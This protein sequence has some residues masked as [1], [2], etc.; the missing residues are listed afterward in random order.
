MNGSSI[1]QSGAKANAKPAE[2]NIKA[3]KSAESDNANTHLSAESA[4]TGGSSDS[5]VS[6]LIRQAKFWHDKMQ[7]AKAMQSLNRVLLSDPHNEEALYLMSLWSYQIND[8]EAAASYREKLSKIAPNS[9]Y[10]QMLDNQRGISDLSSD[11][12]KHA[13]VLASS[14]NINAALIEYQKLFSGATPPKPL[15]AEYYLTMAGDPNYYD[16][17][18]NGVINYIRQNPKD[19]NAQITYGKILSYRKSTIR[20]GIEL[21]DYLAPHTDDA[22]KA[23]RDALIWLSPTNEDEKYYSSYLSRHAND[24]EVRRHFDDTIIGNLSE[25]AYSDA[26]SDKEDAIA[27]FEQIL[28]KNPNNQDALEAV[29]YLQMELKNFVKAQEY[30]NKAASLGGKKE[31]KLRHDAAMAAANLAVQTGDLSL[32]SSTL[33]S[34]L[35]EAPYDVGALMLKADICKK[36]KKFD[37]AERALRTALSAD[38]SN[39]GANEM[40]FY[41]YREQGKKESAD[42]LLSSMPDHVRQKIKQAIAGKGYTDPV[43][44]IRSR[45]ESLAANGQIPAAIETLQEAI[46]KYPNSPWL[47]YDLAKLLGDNGFTAGAQS[48]LGYLTR[49]NA[50]NED[51]FAA[52]SLLNQMG[53][54]NQA[55][56]AVK[57]ISS[58]TAKVSELKRQITISQ[59]FGTVEEYL[60]AGNRQA[61]CNSLQMM[62]ISPSALS[63][64]QLGHMAYLYLQCG[65]KQRALELADLALTRAVDPNA[66]IGDYADLVTVYNQTGYYDK[67]RTL[68]A[69]QSI[70]ANSKQADI[71]RMNIGD[72]IRK[73]D[74]LRDMQHYA[75]AYDILY[76]LIEQNPDDVN[77]NMA[78]ARLYQD[79]GKYVTAGQIYHR[80]LKND[81][82]NQSALEGAINACLADEDFDEAAYLADRLTTSNDP[83]VLTLLARVDAKNKNY[84]GA[85]SKLT[86]ARAQLDR[87]YNYPTAQSA[88]GSLATDS[89]APSHMPGNPFKNR[90]NSSDMMKKTVVMP[91]EDSIGSVSV[92][93][94]STLSSKE[95]ADALNDINFM[96]RDMQ[97]K[98]AMS[99]RFGVEAGQK[100]GEDGLSKLNYASVPISF[101]IPITST[102]Q[103]SLVAEPVSMDSGSLGSASAIYEHGTNALQAGYSNAS[104]IVGNVMN[105]IKNFRDEYANMQTAL[106]DA[107]VSA[108]TID[109]SIAALKSQEK[110]IRASMQELYLQMSTTTDSTEIQE[111][112]NAIQIKN[113]A[114]NTNLESVNKLN[115]V[116]AK[117][118]AMNLAYNLDKLSD[119]ELSALLND[120]HLLPSL[121][122]LGSV[123]TAA[124]KA[125][126]VDI[127]S[128][129]R[130]IITAM[131]GAATANAIMS[132]AKA[133]RA[134]G[135]AFNAAVKSDNY[136]FDIGLTPVG[137]KSTNVEAG[138]FYSFKLNRDSSLNI[139]AERRALRDSLLSYFGYK[140]EMSGTVWGAVTKNGASVQY[141]FDDGYLGGSFSGSLYAYHGKNVARN[142]S[143]SLS[144]TLYVH[145][146]RPTQ[147]ED[148]TVG[149]SLFFQNFRQNQNHFS[150]GNGGYFSPQNYLIASIPFTY[151]KRTE[152]MTFKLA[153]SIG[154]QTYKQ[155][156][157]DY[158]P[159]HSYFQQSLETLA[160]LGFAPAAKFESKDESGVG[161]SIRASVD[162]YV[163]DDLVVGGSLGYSTFGEYKEMYEML[164]IK[165]ILGDL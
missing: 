43:P 5:I 49:P 79:N 35:Q 17:A 40:L 98:V 154:Y 65:Q 6:G 99:V 85:I 161:G 157:Q 71:E 145:A 23:L 94:A 66:G 21:L 84:R 80:I 114:L 63:T 28:K 155:K 88:Q 148:M 126:L 125:K 59:S 44:P 22:D 76:P 9:S 62:Q 33:E 77:L 105:N 46:N 147:Y 61:A 68:T 140:D 93:V 138:A 18:K 15:V 127:A 7:H 134:T 150:L 156:E 163:L 26:D 57:R 123:G 116:K 111:I 78:M 100:D 144:G 92:P 70:I 48:Q 132:G 56:A 51:L 110:D 42:A 39:A 104:V 118:N 106:A 69:N 90:V 72:S 55:M 86:A 58:S 117:L 36:K 64:A 143:Y 74:S 14:G 97:D 160:D 20:K 82:N 165:S 146:M 24:S 41:I 30:L 153:A 87:R 73:A 16:R 121:S 12:L 50:G 133:R 102:A 115:T 122:E 131:K 25:K 159:Q 109:S 13:R 89:G 60:R 108:D 130:T 107:G 83:R 38:P 10:I 54:Y 136:R 3:Q 103:L 124:Q 32:A 137:K 37:D 11:Q 152:N 139:N 45:A 52:A 120:E 129:Y 96:I 8:T 101:N 151:M 34:I 53:Q 164:Y 119:A 128:K 29:G 75:D 142:N 95:R 31:P 112:N 91:W 67:A 81:P 2:S 47:R 27:T 135:V 1:A 158:Y 149:V 113:N 4:I 19:V 141:N 162:Y